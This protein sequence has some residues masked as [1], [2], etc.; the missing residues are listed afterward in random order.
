MALLI[1]VA[2][3]VAAALLDSSELSLMLGGLAVGLATKLG[4]VGGKP[5]GSGIPPMMLVL[6]V[7]L[8][9]A[10]SAAG[11]RRSSIEVRVQEGSRP[12]ETV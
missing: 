3:A 10:S 9:I 5:S 11:A 7:A 12:C 4:A 8:T 2:G 6:L 1:A